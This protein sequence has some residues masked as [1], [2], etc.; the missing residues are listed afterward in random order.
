MAEGMRES[1]EKLAKRGDEY[2]LRVLKGNAY[3]LMPKYIVADQQSLQSAVPRNPSDR[4][5]SGWLRL[6]GGWCLMGGNSHPSADRKRCGGCFNGGTLIKD[7]NRKDLREYT[8]VKPLACIEGKCRW[9]VTRPEYLLEIRAKMMLQADH[10]HTTQL[11]LSQHESELHELKIERAQHVKAH[12]D[13]QFPRLAE[14]RKIEHLVEKLTADSQTLAEGI[15]NAANLVDRLIAV[16]LLDESGGEKTQLVAQG[17]HEDVRW[18][19]EPASSDLLALADICANAEIY[20]ELKP[21]SEAAILRRGNLLDVSLQKQGIGMLFAQLT[22]E[23]MLRLGN[24]V[25]REIARPLND[26]L[27]AAVSMIEFGKVPNYAEILRKLIEEGDYAP[28][29]VSQLLDKYPAPLSP[30][31]SPQQPSA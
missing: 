22:P 1:Q 24:R 10:L 16:E 2:T 4:T 30:S 3:E 19:F 20:P 31:L 12:P 26:S 25:I 15:G 18:S 11:H 28:I 6:L 8:S 17:S 9:F 13:Q 27:E 14:L 29:Q 5:S 21:E 23:Q 7:S